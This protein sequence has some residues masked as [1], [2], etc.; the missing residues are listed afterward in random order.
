M[1]MTDPVADLFTRLRNAAIARRK[2]AD[3]PH[4]RLRENLCQLLVREGFLR[5]AQVTE[6][7]LRKRL[8]AY[9]RVDPDG[10]SVITSIQRVS[11]PGCRVYRDSSQ[12]ER[13]L[14]GL[15]VGIYSTPKGLLTDTE[16]REQKVGGEYMGKVW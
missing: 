6:V 2:H 10:K 15:G 12:I 9:L 1:S 3:M 11:R 14:R 5:E 13:V 16:C 8:R 7:G 4:S